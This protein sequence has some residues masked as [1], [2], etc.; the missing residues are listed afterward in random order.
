[1]AG[2]GFIPSG[3]PGLRAELKIT[4]NLEKSDIVPSTLRRERQM[5]FDGIPFLPVKFNLVAT[6]GEAFWVP[7]L[8]KD[9]G[10]TWCLLFEAKPGGA[11][12]KC[13]A[14]RRAL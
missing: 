12:D 8:H 6:A 10:A 14:R 13:C 5:G 11:L 3:I 4:R 1:M 7:Y 2:L 9:H